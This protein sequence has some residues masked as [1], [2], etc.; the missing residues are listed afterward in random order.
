VIAEDKKNEYVDVDS[1]PNTELTTPA[2]SASAA[3]MAMTMNATRR[4]RARR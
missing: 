2:I 4:W 1:A 3:R